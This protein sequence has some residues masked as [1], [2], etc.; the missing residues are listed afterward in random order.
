MTGRVEKV[1]GSQ[2]GDPGGGKPSILHFIRCSPSSFHELQWPWAPFP[3]DGGSLVP[4][5]D[6]LGGLIGPGDGVGDN[7]DGDHN[8]ISLSQHLAHG[9]EQIYYMPT[10]FCAWKCREATP[11]SLSSKSS[12]SSRGTIGGQTRRSQ[13]LCMGQ[14]AVMTPHPSRSLSSPLSSSL[15]GYHVA[16]TSIHWI[17]QTHSILSIRHQ[18]SLLL[19]EYFSQSHANGYFPLV[20]KGHAP[21]EVTIARLPT[22]LQVYCNGSLGPGAGHCGAHANAQLCSPAGGSNTDQGAQG[23]IGHGLHTK[24]MLPQGCSQPL[25]VHSWQNRDS[26]NEQP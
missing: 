12:Q 7:C 19:V 9:R 1:Q 18:V 5:K 13:S 6:S 11:S 26:S 23:C 21:K 24:A 2:Q 14:L 3:W 16:S 10:R 8:G 4:W 25:P 22:I 15:L 17:G 20:C